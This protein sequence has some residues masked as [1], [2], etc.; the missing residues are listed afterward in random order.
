[1]WR[2]LIGDLEPAAEFAEPASE[3]ALGDATAT[4]GGELPAPLV[5]LL[6]E[7]NGVQGRHGIDLVWP[8][9]RV[10]ADNLLFR[11]NPE[12]AALYMPFDP[13]LFFAGAGN[14]DQFAFLWTPRRDEVFVWDHESDSRRW[15]AGSLEQYLRWWL[16]G[17]LKV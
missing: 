12:F 16:D 7:S 14:G 10:V 6:R 9:E 17:T 2:E 11:T 8:L 4:L 1:V 3:Q 5:E 13:L 15:V